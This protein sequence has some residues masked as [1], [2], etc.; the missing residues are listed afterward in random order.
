MTDF[1]A[2]LATRGAGLLPPSTPRPALT[3]SVAV[4]AE[5]FPGE[6]T[7]ESIAEQTSVVAEAPPVIH[8]MPRRTEAPAPPG[9]TDPAP[10][11]HPL[12]T[13]SWAKLE[14]GSRTALAPT[15]CNSIAFAS[16]LRPS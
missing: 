4:P 2:G 11:P 5:A 3:P 15:A 14:G 8:E 16:T 13:P 6:V 9:F 10:A 1:L 7:G 12:P